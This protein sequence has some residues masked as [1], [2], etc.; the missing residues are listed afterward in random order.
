MLLVLE[1]VL[2]AEIMPILQMREWD[3]GLKKE[4]KK[5]EKLTPPPRYPPKSHKVA[6][7]RLCLKIRVCL[8]IYTASHI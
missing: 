4:K 7:I 6:K 5:K 8:Q 2:K 1:T 3:R